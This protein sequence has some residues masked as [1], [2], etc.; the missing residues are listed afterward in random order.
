MF[1]FK[2]NYKNLNIPSAKNETFYPIFYNGDFIDDY[3]M[4]VIV[5]R[6]KTDFEVSKDFK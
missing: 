1:T 6:E 2:I 5:D 3:I 4:K